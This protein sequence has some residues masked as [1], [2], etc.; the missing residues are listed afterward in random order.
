MWLESINSELL[1]IFMA[2]SSPDRDSLTG[3]NGSQRRLLKCFFGGGRS[4]LWS[5]AWPRKN[6]PG[7]CG[8]LFFDDFLE[9]LFLFRELGL[10]L[11]M[12]AD[13]QH[14][15]NDGENHQPDGDRAAEQDV[16]ITVRNDQRPS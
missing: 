6:L 4:L 8:E 16:E 12:A 14:Q 2:I 1:A 10:D 11:F 13:R 3:I 9:Q 5:N 15:R 7:P